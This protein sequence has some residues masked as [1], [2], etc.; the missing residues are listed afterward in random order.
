MQAAAE[1][2]RHAAA[3]V[4]GQDVGP[5][6]VAV[7][8]SPTHPAAGPAGGAASRAPSNASHVSGTESSPG[9][10]AR[11]QQEAGG[12]WA[13]APPASTPP[14]VTVTRAPGGA[15]EQFILFG[16]GECDTS[17][18]WTSAGSAPAS[19]TSSWQSVG[20]GGGG[21]GLGAAPA[22][23]VALASALAAGLPQDGA[24]GALAAQL[25]GFVEAH[26]PPP[27]EAG[28]PMGSWARHEQ[29][30]RAGRITA[31]GSEASRASTSGTAS[32]AVPTTRRSSSRAEGARRGGESGG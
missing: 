26:R 32:A 7:D 2:A 30:E 19:A 15:P 18:R 10:E 17:S 20:S 22:T 12:R 13:K 1:A 6:R 4:I 8:P 3:A 14:T 31:T 29:A 21:S 27:I 25:R 28:P 11:W 23:Q 5:I 9:R 16:Q 24:G